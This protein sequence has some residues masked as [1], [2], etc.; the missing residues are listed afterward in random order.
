MPHKDPQAYREYMRVYQ[1]KQH[2][3]KPD[4]RAP[5]S[6]MAVNPELLV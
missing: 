2:E 5:E 6:D 3:R 4:E 1:R